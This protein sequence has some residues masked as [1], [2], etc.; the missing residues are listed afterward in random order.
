MVDVLTSDQRRLNMSRIRGKQ[1]KPEM[2]LRRV[3]RTMPDRMLPG[4]PG[5]VFPKYYTRLI[6][7]WFCHAH[8]CPQ[9]NQP[10]TRQDFCG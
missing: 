2:L 3:L 8:R 5:L 6:H 1:M 7:G 4:R 9:S 10:A